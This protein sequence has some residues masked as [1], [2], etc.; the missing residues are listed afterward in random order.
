MDHCHRVKMST[1]WSGDIKNAAAVTHA[2]LQKYYNR[3][4]ANVYGLSM[5][6]CGISFTYNLH[7][8]Y[9]FGLN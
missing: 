3:A 9:R 2:K 5:S 4:W 7:I 1:S 6:E 8:D